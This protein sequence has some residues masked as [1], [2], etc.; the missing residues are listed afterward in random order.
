MR[1]LCTLSSFFLL[2]LLLLSPVFASDDGTVLLPSPT[3]IFHIEYELPYPGLLPD[4]P[5]YFLKTTRDRIVGMLISDPVK[6]AEFDL[7]QAEKRFQAGLMLYQRDETKKDVAVTALSK[8]Q[9]YLDAAITTIIEV[10]KQKKETGDFP[11]IIRH[12]IFK[13]RELLQ[14]VAISHPSI[15]KNIEELMPN[16]DNSLKKLNE[17][18]PTE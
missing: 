15:R 13:Q 11:N 17:K 4:N 16:L 6:K 5:L 9:T 14:E 1:F 3:P 12:S 10:K 2:F 7:L 8:G 18:F